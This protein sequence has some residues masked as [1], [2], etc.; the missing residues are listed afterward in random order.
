MC[1]VSEV[2]KLVTK[3]DVPPH[4][5]LL[6][7]VPLFAEDEDCEQTPTIRYLLL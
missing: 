3:A 1:S 4:K 2:V 5:K 6:D 7:L